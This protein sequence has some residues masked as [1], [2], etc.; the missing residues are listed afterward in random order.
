MGKHKPCVWVRENQLVRRNAEHGAELL[1]HWQE[2]GCPPAAGHLDRIG[3]NRSA[4][5]QGAGELA[6]GVQEEIVETPQYYRDGQLQR[7]LARCAL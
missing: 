4:V 1:G 3:D 6:Q 5:S 7:R 2:A